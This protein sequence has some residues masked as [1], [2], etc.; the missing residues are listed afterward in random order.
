MKI[1]LC[2]VWLGTSPPFPHRDMTSEPNQVVIQCHE[3][4]GV[5][6]SSV[7]GYLGFLAGDTFFLA[8]LANGLPDAFNE[9]RFFTFS[10][11]LFCGVWTAFLP[12]YQ[13]LWASTLW[14]WRSSPS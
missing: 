1:I 7:L 8:F 13:V 6:F 14:L 9:T 3:G 12:L 10:M 11:L 5:A 4:S 2:G